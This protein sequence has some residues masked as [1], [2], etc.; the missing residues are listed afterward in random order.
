MCYNWETELYGE[1]YENVVAYWP[2]NETS[3]SIAVDYA[4]FDNNGTIEEAT[5]GVEGKVGTA[6]YYEGTEQ[7]VTV[8]DNS[9]LQFGTNN[10]TIVAWVKK[11]D[12]TFARIL[13]KSGYQNSSGFTFDDPGNG[14]LRFGIRH[15]NYSTNEYQSN[16][17]ISDNKWHHV[18]AVRDGTTVRIYMD[19]QKEEQTNYFVNGNDA[20]GT[21]QPVLVGT[22]NIGTL[23]EVILFNRAL[24]D[25][26]IEQLYYN[27]GGQTITEQ[28]REGLIG[29]WPFEDNANDY[30]ESGNY[31]LTYASPSYVTG[32]VG[33]GVLIPGIHDLRYYPHRSTDDSI[34]DVPSNGSLT[35][36]AWAKK[37]TT[38]SSS[39]EAIVAKEDETNPYPGWLLF[40]QPTNECGPVTNAV[41]LD[42]KWSNS[43]RRLARATIQFP[44]NGKWQHV[45]GVIDRSNEKIYIY[46]QGNDVTYNSGSTNYCSRSITNL[47]ELNAEK[48]LGV[49]VRD[50]Q[51]IH[52][53]FNGNIDEV[54]IWNRALSAEEISALY[55]NGEGLSLIQ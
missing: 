20:P 47:G 4:G 33:R 3:G 54:A 52:N 50:P 1:C 23:D 37:T 46:Q 2:L 15:P 55:N 19:N 36:C 12:T 35:V 9:N 42:T 26:E 13:Y 43:S 30:S 25:S 48:G 38:I 39:A 44:T 41:G 8:S 34:F 14:H 32:V 51:V 21:G 18:V 17:I 24:S 49:G 45:C 27:S 29:Y 10:F 7:K 31:D 11:P 22:D 28:L 5:F 40:L 6:Y 53:K 16:F